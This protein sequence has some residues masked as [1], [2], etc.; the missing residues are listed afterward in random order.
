MAKRHSHL[1]PEGRAY[2]LT[3]KLWEAARGLPARRVAIA[4]I[5]EF[6]QDCWFVGRNLPK[7]PGGGRA[8]APDHGGRSFAPDHSF[9]RRSAD[10]WWSSHRQ[11]VAGGR[12]RDRAV[13]FE[14]V[15]LSI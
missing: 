13:R 12:D 5:R 2:W 11:G 10:G 1:T 6:E 4:D 14:V 9:Q 15:A 7:L 3:E 8:C